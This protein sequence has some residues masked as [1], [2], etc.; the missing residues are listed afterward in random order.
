MRTAALCLA[1]LCVLGVFA[2]CGA[3][4]EEEVMA[5]PTPVPEP[6]P[7][8]GGALRLPMPVNPDLSDPLKVNTEE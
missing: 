5:A 8:S 6:A 3:P 1:V 7:T 4:E 2:G